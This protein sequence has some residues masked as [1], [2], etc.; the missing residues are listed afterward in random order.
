MASPGQEF[1]TGIGSIASILRHPFSIGL[2]GNSGNL[3]SANLKIDDEEHEVTGHTYPREHF[4]AEDV[5][6][7]CGPPMGLQ[8]GL[9]GQYSSSNRSRIQPSFKG[10]FA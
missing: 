10:E 8:D 5:S 3:D 6:Y 9:P 1:R 2:L 7:R 4:D